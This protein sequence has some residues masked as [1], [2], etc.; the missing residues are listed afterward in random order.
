MSHL[1]YQYTKPN[2]C[3]FYSYLVLISLFY[4]IDNEVD[5]K[6][7]ASFKLQ[8]ISNKKSATKQNTKIRTTEH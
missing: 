8:Q 5:I 1:P 7:I 4:L 2:F 6:E 3:L